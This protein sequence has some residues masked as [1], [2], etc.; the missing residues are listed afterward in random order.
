M[1]ITAGDLNLSLLLYSDDIV[2]FA[3]TA[4]DLQLQLIKCFEPVVS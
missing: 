1:G 2:L 4:G 3:G